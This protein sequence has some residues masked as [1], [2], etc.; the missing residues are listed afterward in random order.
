M[1]A[2]LRVTS[3]KIADRLGFMCAQVIADDV[4]GSFWS[5]TGDEIFQKGDELCTGVA[6]TGLADDL[7]APGIK[8][9]VERERSMAIIFKAVSFSPTGRE[10]QDGVQTIQRLDGTLFV[11][12]EH[13]G[14]ERRFEVQP[15]D[16]GGFL[17]EFRIGTGHIAAQSMGLDPGPSP[18]PSHPAVGNTQIPCQLSGAPMSRSI[19][20]RLLS[21][22][23]NPGLQGNDLFRDNL[24]T[25]S[26]IQ[27]RQAFF[28]KTL[29][30]PSNEV[31]ATTFLFIMAR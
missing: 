16:I 14:V 31:L 3:Q 25:M 7:A 18:H 15:D 19:G 28:N 1:N 26:G 2:Y 12:T 9:C 30:P 24:A 10:R 6:G 4:N 29:F 27:T 23:Q 21:R 5:L 8:G 20:R 17:F 11:D 22:F 13:C